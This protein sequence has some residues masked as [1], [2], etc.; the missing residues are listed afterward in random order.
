MPYR[1]STG[2]FLQIPYMAGYG[3]NLVAL[4]PNGVSAFRFADAMI[5][6]VP[7][8]IRAGEAIRPFCA[9][10]TTTA[11]PARTPLGASELRAELPGRT[12][13]SALSRWGLDPSGVIRAESK[14]DFD[15]GRWIITDDGKYCRTWNVWERGQ[16]GCFTVYRDGETFELHGIDRWALIRVTRTPEAVER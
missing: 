12:F 13:E 16:P 3:G 7:A 15:V 10:A 5:Y 1:T 11:A 9:S 8:L 4:L 14:S 6:D 2:C